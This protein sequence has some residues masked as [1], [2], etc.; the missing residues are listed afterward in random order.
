MNRVTKKFLGKVLPPF[1][2]MGYVM[3]VMTLSTM[4]PTLALQIGIPI[5]FLLVPLFGYM[6]YESWKDAK[7]E[8]EWEDRDLL[9]D[10]ESNV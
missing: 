9:R 5:V 2:I 1:G 4:A 8:V 3:V 6:F 7:R 10:I